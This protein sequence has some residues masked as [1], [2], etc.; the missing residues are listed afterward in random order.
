MKYSLVTFLLLL[1]F[2]NTTLFA[3]E[4]DWTDEKKDW[5]DEESSSSKFFAGINV[6]G[7][8]VNN[9]TAKIYTGTNEVSTWGI[10]YILS[11]PSYKIILDDYFKYSYVVSEFPQNPTYKA[12]LDIG[13]HAGI[14]LGKG[15]TIYIDINS[16]TVK[17]EQVFTI[18]INDPT[19]QSIEPTYEQFPIIGEE[20]RFNLNLGTQL[21][22]FNTEKTTIYFPL[23]GKKLYCNR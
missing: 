12:A 22:L 23:F 18:E 20:K 8:F 13:L 16:A 6:G 10:N 9:N 11:V 4:G 15:N 14:N 5:T 19:T 7:L 2:C 3:Q 1:T 17:Y 21:S